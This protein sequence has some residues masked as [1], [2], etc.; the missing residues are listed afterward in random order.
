VNCALKRGVI[1]EFRLNKV[2]PEV[3][4]R[5]KETTS[6]NRIHNK[7]E[8]FINNGSKD[9]SKNGSGSFSSQ[10][11]KYKQGKDKKKILVQAIKTEEVEVKAFKEDAAS[12]SGYDRGS[13]ID[14]K[15]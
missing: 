8:I 10:L 6:A 2:D 15:K 1:M 7:R 9:K 11:G 13:I 14:V 12:E 3:R 4:R 5:V